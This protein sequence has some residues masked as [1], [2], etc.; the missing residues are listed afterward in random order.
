[1]TDQPALPGFTPPPT[2]LLP[3][4]IE[5]THPC[6][7]LIHFKDQACR[8]V[9]LAND[10]GAYCSVAQDFDQAYNGYGSY[11]PRTELRLYTDA[12]W[13]RCE[14]F[15]EQREGALKELARCFEKLKS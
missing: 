9:Y 3:N 5:E 8:I 4:D 1:M 2:G 10:R 15:K 14:A 6:A 11:V 13:A 12:L 7:Q